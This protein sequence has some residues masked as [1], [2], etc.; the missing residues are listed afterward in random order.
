MLSVFPQDLEQGVIDALDKSILRIKKGY[1]DKRLSCKETL[2][3]QEMMREF[4]LVIVGIKK[5][6][7]LLKEIKT[8]S[9]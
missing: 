8:I 3:V 9:Q 7:S 1:E 6:K 4:I 2:D 5:I